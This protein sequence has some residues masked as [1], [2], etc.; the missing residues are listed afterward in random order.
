MSFSQEILTRQTQIMHGELAGSAR[1]TQLRSCC[2]LKDGGIPCPI[3]FGPK[4][5]C[6]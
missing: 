3:F 5:S 2:F 4:A 1:L 6:F